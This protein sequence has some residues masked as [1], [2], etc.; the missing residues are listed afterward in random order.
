[1]KKR[2]IILLAFIV[3]IWIIVNS[4][5]VKLAYYQVRY[6]SKVPNQSWA[7]V[8][9]YRSNDNY[10]VLTINYTGKV[11]KAVEYSS[12]REL[13]RTANI[14]TQ[15]IVSP[16]SYL[17]QSWSKVQDSL[18]E[19]HADSGNG[20]E[21]PSYFTT[22]GYLV[23]FSVEDDIVMQVLKYDLFSGELVEH[24]RTLPE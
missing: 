5:S 24:Y 1:M 10:V 6:T 23:C 18:G 11:T 7:E 8:E 13:L 15:T 4:N 20:F 19:A 17:Y 3:L 14:S 16:E 21:Y 12:E 9:V 22:D 2:I